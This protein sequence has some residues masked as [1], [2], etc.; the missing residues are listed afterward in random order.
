MFA[1]VAPRVNPQPQEGATEDRKKYGHENV[2]K[3]WQKCPGDEQGR[4]Q[5]DVEHVERQPGQVHESAARIGWHAG[6]QGHEEAAEG[7][8]AAHRDAD[9]DEQV[10]IAVDVVHEPQGAVGYICV[11]VCRHD[12]V[13]YGGICWNKKQI[14]IL[15]KCRIQCKK[16]EILS[17]KVHF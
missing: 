3:E 1:H 8:E 14:F 12:P 4:R 5:H 10:L 15:K 7:V 9:V 11:P 17:K 6:P 13:L 16:S 2:H